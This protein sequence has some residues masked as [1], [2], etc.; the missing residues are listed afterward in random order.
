MYDYSYL[1]QDGW[2]V[3]ELRCLSRTHNER[4]TSEPLKFSNSSY[5]VYSLNSVCCQDWAFSLQE[6][7][8]ESKGSLNFWVYGQNPAV[9]PFK[10]NLFGSIVF[11]QFTNWNYEVFLLWP[12]LVTYM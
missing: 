4:Q 11:Q 10:W 12:L 6:W 7:M 1:G 5:Q 3:S 9:W 8:R 2:R